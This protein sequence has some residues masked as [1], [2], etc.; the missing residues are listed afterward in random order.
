VRELTRRP[1]STAL[2]ERQRHLPV[3]RQLRVG[4]ADDAAE[5][6]ADRI[7]KEVAAGRRTDATASLM[8]APTSRITRTTA[9]VIRRSVYLANDDASIYK[10]T[11]D[12]TLELAYL[13]PRGGNYLLIDYARVAMVREV[14]LGMLARKYGS[15]S[16][17]T[18]TV[19]ARLHA[20]M[21]R[22]KHRANAKSRKDGAKRAKGA[23]GRKTTVPKAKT[24]KP[25]LV[26]P[27]AAELAAHDRA[28]EL[29]GDVSEA[30]KDAGSAFGKRLTDALGTVYGHKKDQLFEVDL[31]PAQLVPLVIAA[32]FS[33]PQQY[34]TGGGSRL[35]AAAGLLWVTGAPDGVTREQVLVFLG[36]DPLE[37]DRYAKVGLKRVDATAFDRLVAEQGAANTY[38]FTSHDGRVRVL[39]SSLVTTARASNSRIQVAGRVYT[40]AEFAALD[41]N[42][43]DGQTIGRKYAR[44]GP[45]AGASAWIRSDALVAKDRGAGQAAAMQQWNALGAAAYANRYLAKRYDLAQN[46]EWL[47]VR[48]AQIG[49]T[50]DAANLVAGLYATNSAMIPFES[51]IEHWASV[52]N[53]NN[54]PSSFHARFV[55]HGVTGVFCTSIELQISATRHP[56]LG[57][58]TGQSLATFDPLTGKVV[59]KLANELV[60]RSIDRRVGEMVPC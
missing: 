19:G 17:S 54:D 15:T 16:K 43:P 11:D 57:T 5:L 47:H 2:A 39:Y 50:T 36:A 38:S 59:D 22:D 52:A 4:A 60:K 46:W 1:A 37:L 56:E 34:R 45:A 10:D 26:D 25:S 29:R 35:P 48:G 30:L 55:A 58:L 12:D 51:M 14:V 6:E 41:P 31:K 21:Q 8:S 44:L 24:G 33:G 13:M 53:R 18:A 28:T 42:A 3:R 49:G 40:D 7:A 9:P 20:P 23:G 32:A 27:A